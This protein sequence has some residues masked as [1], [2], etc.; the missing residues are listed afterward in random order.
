MRQAALSGTRWTVGARVG[1]QLF[2]WPIT[3]FVIRVLEPGDYGL[4][5]MATVTIGFIALFSELGLGAALVQAKTLDEASAR[6]ACSVI[7]A[8][9]A[10]IVLALFLAAPVM[11]MW[12]HEPRLVDVVR[13]LTLELVVSSFA[14]VPQAQLERQLRFKQLSMA[15]MSAGACGAVVTLLLALFGAGVWSLVGGNLTVATLR[16]AM[17]VLFNNRLVLPSLDLVPARGLVRF[18]SH[19]LASRVLWYWCSQSD[20]VILARLLHTSVL[21]HYAVAA[22][23]AMLP[24]N[25]AMEIINRIALPVLSRM[26]AAPDGLRGMHLRLLGLVAT[27]AFGT[28]W[29]LA[30][31]A[32]EFAVFVLGERWQ[33]ASIPLMLLAAVAPLRMLSALNNTVSSSAGVPQASTIELALAGVLIPAGVLAGAW[34]DG[35][36][37]ACLAWAVVYPLIYVISNAMTCKAVGT[38]KT[39]GMLPMAAPTLAAI[40]MWICVL[41]IRWF[42][43]AKLNVG[44]LLATEL[45]IAAASY[46]VAMHLLAPALVREARALVLE[47]LRPH[48][49]ARVD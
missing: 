26:H 10:A 18:G 19:V 28:C 21:G 14:V 33:A 48:R 27:Y 40:V 39:R 37:G 1:L 6:A 13:I 15:T 43:S 9:N 3:I 4:L 30:A 41:A 36:R 23:L 12:F 8:C 24:A 2:T 49:P 34:L 5:A 44:V 22:Q 46:V 17:I 20:Q 29:G 11:A 35:L 16:S 45:V 31:V 32:P 7:L 47:L 42:F 25:K 38:P